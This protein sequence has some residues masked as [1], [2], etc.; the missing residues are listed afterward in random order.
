[1]GVSSVPWIAQSRDSLKAAAVL[2]ARGRA[3]HSLLATW[4]LSLICASPA[5]TPPCLLRAG[6]RNLVNDG[7]FEEV[8]EVLVAGTKFVYDAIYKQGIELGEPGAPIVLL[9]YAFS[10]FC[11]CKRMR[12]VEGTPGQG[13]HCGK[14]ALRLNGSIYLRARSAAK[15]G[16]VFK[17]R[18]YAKG[19]GKVRFILHLT[20]TKGKYFGQVVPKLVAI[21]TN[22]WVLVEQTLDTTGKPN[23]KRV[24]PRME[25]MGD[26]Y[27]DDLVLVKE[28][29]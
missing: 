2:L 12:V 26:M 4:L 3:M 28:Q 9:P 22:D 13:V 7:G 20:N 14:R 15:T 1:M 5:S 27:L 10:Q 29:K 8:R 21:D 23:L 16:D 19:K 24:W 18:F 17:A 6:E 25:A 11:G